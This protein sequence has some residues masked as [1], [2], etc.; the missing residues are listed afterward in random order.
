[1]LVCH[2]Y[3]FCKNYLC[4]VYAGGYGV[5]SESGICVFRKLC[6]VGF[7]VVGENLLVLL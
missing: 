7:L 3:D 4:N 2:Q 5:L 1:M 6:L